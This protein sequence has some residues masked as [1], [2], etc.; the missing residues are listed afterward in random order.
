M[1]ISLY[2]WFI[3]DWLKGLH[4]IL[5]ALTVENYAWCLL[6]GQLWNSVIRIIRCEWNRRKIGYPERD[7]I[8]F[9]SLHGH[10]RN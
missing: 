9:P 5:L 4:I 10:Y 7:L 3:W 8:F 2:L 1:L 6:V